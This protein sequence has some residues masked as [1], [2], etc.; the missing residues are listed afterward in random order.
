M[1]T[2]YLI[3]HAQA[4]SHYLDATDAERVLTPTGEQQARALGAKFQQQQIQPAL[5]V[6]SPAQRALT[7]ATLIANATHYPVANIE[8]QSLLYES[9]VARVLKLIQA[10]PSHC[11][12]VLIVGHNPTLTMLVQ[13]LHAD[14][15]TH[16]STCDCVGFAVAE[17]SWSNLTTLTV[18]LIK[19]SLATPHVSD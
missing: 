3:R 1:K 10:L 12:N 17:S 16:L 11:A 9:S 4:A 6:S 19:F 13:N 7:T 18:Q 15:T 5:I 14:F 8:L 2:V